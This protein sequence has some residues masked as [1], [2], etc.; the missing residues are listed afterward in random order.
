M[1]KKRAPSEQKAQ[2]L[3]ALLQGHAEG[4]SGEEL[5]SLLVRLSTERIL[6]EALEQEQAM[7]LGRGR[8]ELR[9]KKVGYRNGYENGTLKTGEGV[10]HVKVPQIR[11]QAE[12]YRSQ[13]WNNLSHTSEV[14]KKLI[15]EMYVGGCRSGIL[16]RG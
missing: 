10:L 8:Y 3:R 13:L 11:G 5:L 14:L 1:E 2:V 12:P 4:Q 6:Q 9:G 16:S 15:V 7:A